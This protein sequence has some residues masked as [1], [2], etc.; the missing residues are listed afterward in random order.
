M[1]LECWIQISVVKRNRSMMTKVEAIIQPTKLDAVKEVLSG[2]GIDGLTIS[3][4]RGHAPAKR[5]HRD[6][7]GP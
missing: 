1:F 5:S 7:S 6:V 2:L 4:V 3:E